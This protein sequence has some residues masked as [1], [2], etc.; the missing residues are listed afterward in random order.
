M[1]N[2]V[3]IRK[4]VM[5]I[6]INHKKDYKYISNKFSKL[7]DNT[8]YKL[9]EK[10]F[11]SVDND[12]RFKTLEVDL[13]I[14]ETLAPLVNGNTIIVS[15]SGLYSHQDLLRMHALGISCFLVGE[16]L[17]REQDVEGATKRLLGIEKQT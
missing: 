12:L 14:T 4:A 7:I 11:S 9:I 8:F 3:V 15:E 6:N 13:R 1:D 16:S 17:M 10:K 5:D 2:S